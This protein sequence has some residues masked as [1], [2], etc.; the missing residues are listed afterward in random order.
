MKRLITGLFAVGLIIAALN[1]ATPSSAQAATPEW[2]S[3]V[4]TSMGAHLAR[5]WFDPGN[6]NEV[7]VLS[8]TVEGKELR[9][10]MDGIW[11]GT[12]PKPD[13]LQGRQV[14]FSYNHSSTDGNWAA[15]LRPKPRGLYS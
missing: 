6:L 4:R 15:C 7:P 2:P 11:V 3:C 14:F 5:Y 13:P 8:V 10:R 9:R 12:A 1:L